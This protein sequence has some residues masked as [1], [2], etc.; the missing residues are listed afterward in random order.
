VHQTISDLGVGSNSWLVDDSSVLNGLLA[1]ALVAAFFRTMRTVL[2]ERWRWLLS[3]L[4]AL[5]PL[6]FAVAGIFNEAP[7]TLNVHWLVGADLGLVGPV[8]AFAV[9]GVV[10]RGDRR[11]RG[12][13]TYSLVASGVTV[14]LVGLMFWVFTPGTTLTGAHLGG[15]MERI[16][17]FEVLGWYV[18]IGLR[19]LREGSGELTTK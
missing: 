18:A 19:I 3:G 10:L 16:V 6:G 13:G 12:W 4:I 7:S 15:L 11:W 8:I 9:V 2:T 14:V 17:V 5:P 1:I